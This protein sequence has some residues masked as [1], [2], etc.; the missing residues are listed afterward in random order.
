[1]IDGAP[2]LQAVARVALQVNG[3]TVD[4]QSVLPQIQPEQSSFP[5]SQPWRPDA[6]GEYEVTVV[7]FSSEDEALGTATVLLEVKEASSAA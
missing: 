4:V 3:Q 5:L 1:T 6:V 7:A 2:D